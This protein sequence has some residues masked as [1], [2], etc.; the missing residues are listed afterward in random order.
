MLLPQAEERVGL[1]LGQVCNAFAGIILSKSFRALWQWGR[2]S[3]FGVAGFNS[4]SS[5]VSEKNLVKSSEKLQSHI[6]VIL[7]LKRL[8]KRDSSEFKDSMDT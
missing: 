5:S 2:S 7:A 1:A 8:K 6:L 4:N 3:Q